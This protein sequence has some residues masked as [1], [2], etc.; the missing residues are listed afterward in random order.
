VWVDAAAV[1]LHHMGQPMAADVPLTEAATSFWADGAK[2]GVMSDFA[3][4][5]WPYDQPTDSYTFHWL[6]DSG[7]A[8]PAYDGMWFD[9]N[10]GLPSGL[11][12]ERGMGWWYRSRDD[13]TRVGSPYW[14]WTEPVPY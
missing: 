12:L 14:N 13:A 8:Y 7:G 10:T 3:D 5:I 6:F 2:G 9:L 1:K 11:I 4:Q